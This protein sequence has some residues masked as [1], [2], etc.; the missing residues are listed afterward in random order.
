MILRDADAAVP[1]A[2]Y[3]NANW[4]CPEEDL[5][6]ALVAPIGGVAPL[7]E[8][9]VDARGRLRADSG[10][11]GSEGRIKKCYIATQVSE[12]AVR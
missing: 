8:P 7:R 6:P 1:G 4:V 2:D 10:G 9:P 11:G 5:P 3:I 12:S